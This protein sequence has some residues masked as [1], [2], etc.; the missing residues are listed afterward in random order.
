[1]GFNKRI[2]NMQMLSSYYTA[3]REVGISNAIGKTDGFI[4]QD[5]DSSRVISLWSEGN[6]DEARKIMEEYVLR[7]PAET[8]S[9]NR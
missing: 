5:V 8:S 4:F 1:M 9:D 2:F 3:D 6:W 7:I